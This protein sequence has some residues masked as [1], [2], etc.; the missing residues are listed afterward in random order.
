MQHCADRLIT[1]RHMGGCGNGPFACDFDELLMVRLDAK[2]EQ[3]H[4]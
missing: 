4:G 2:D 1:I 3:A